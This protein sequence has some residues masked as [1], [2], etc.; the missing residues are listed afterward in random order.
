MNPMKAQVVIGAYN[1]IFDKKTLF[2]YKCCNKVNGYFIRKKYWRI[3]E[4]NYPQIADEVK[5]NVE[6][7]YIKNIKTRVIFEQKKFI[8]RMKKSKGNEYVM[9]VTQLQQNEIEAEAKNEATPEDEGIEEEYLE[10]QK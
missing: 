7:E 6:H 4:E 9:Y 3:L 1:C 2:L 5:E 8:E 10:Y